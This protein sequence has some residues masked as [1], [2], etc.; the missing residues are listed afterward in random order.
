MKTQPA[1]LGL[2][3]D[4]DERLRRLLW[5]LLITIAAAGATSL[6]APGRIEPDVC[7]YWGGVAN[8]RPSIPLSAVRMT[9]Q[10]EQP[11]PELAES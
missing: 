3:P 4:P 11:E 1:S 9:V 6:H 2:D 5:Y 10:P 8:A 7:L